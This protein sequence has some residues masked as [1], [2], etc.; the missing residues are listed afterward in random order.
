MKERNAVIKDWRGKLRVALVYPN[1]YRAGMANL[2]MHVLYDLL[3]SIEDCY[4]ERFFLDF[5]RSLET[6]SPLRDFD[7]IAFSWQFELDA[8]N[9]LKIL[10]RGEIPAGREE[11]KGKPLVIVGGPCA[12]NPLPLANFADVFLI[13][14]A[15]GVIFEFIEKYREGGLE[16]LAGMGPLYLPGIKETAVR[17]YSSNLD[18]YHPTTQ[19]MSPGASFGESLLVEVCRGCNRGCRF[20]MG[21]Y[22]FRPRRERGLDNLVQIIEEGIEQ[23]RPKKIALI[24]ASASDHSEM[25]ALCEFLGETGLGISMPS[26]RADTLT[27]SLVKTI[28]KSGQR[29]LTIAP[30]SNQ[31]VRGLM[32]KRMDDEDILGA[33]RLAFETGIKTLKLYL[34]VGYPGESVKDVEETAKL[35]RDIRK[36]GKG[37]VKA[38][39]APFVPKPHTPLQWSGME[40]IKDTKRKL[41]I[42]KK[43]AP[44]EVEVESPRLA[45]LQT[46]IARGD[47]K[48]GEILERALDASAIK[49]VSREASIDIESYTFGRERD[50]A[51]PWERI[52]VG[53]K[54]AFLLREYE[55]VYEDAG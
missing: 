18:D 33:A 10:K 54:R 23:S 38:S 51:L 50:T 29:S 6:G 14:E 48:I 30:E 3:N 11:R 28:V 13:G 8:L 41:R 19:V 47:E 53:T 16:S 37:R 27:R 42:L 36:A 25:D 9:M 39:V 34:M 24:G 45:R 32:G 7:I 15:E 35:L 31:R 55:K 49:R 2:G 40:D 22:I 5:E 46:I 1:L 21:G 12:V 43:E 4:C 44:V 26:V 17:A 20:C 52:D